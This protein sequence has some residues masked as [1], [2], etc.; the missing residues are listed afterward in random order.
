MGEIRTFVF[1]H[2]ETTGLPERKD[3]PKMNELS[4]VAVQAGHIQMNVFPRVQNKLH[5]CFNPCKEISPHAKYMSELTNEL[6]EEMP[7]FCKK[8]VEMIH[9]FLERLPQ[10]ICLVAHS[11]NTFDFPILQNEISTT[12]SPLAQK[13]V[14]YLCA[15]SV[16]IFEDIHIATTTDFSHFNPRPSFKLPDV[17]YRLTNQTPE[18]LIRAEDDVL[19]LIRCAAVSGKNFVKWAHLKAKQNWNMENWKHNLKI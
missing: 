4:I 14:N 9:D 3:M 18:H 5:F 8:T 12:G 11:G 13:F 10:P 16:E 19:R 15:D 2:S 6:L 17:Y 1:I 7:K